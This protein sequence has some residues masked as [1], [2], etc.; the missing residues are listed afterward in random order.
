MLEL[1]KQLRAQGVA[2]ILISHNLEHVF[3]VADRIA[4]LRR[5][6]NAGTVHTGESSPS[7]IVHFITGAEFGVTARTAEEVPQN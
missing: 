1:I 5:G 6:S 4:V 3:S 7:E 2:Q